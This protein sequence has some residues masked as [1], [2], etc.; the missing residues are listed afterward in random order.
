MSALP[1]KPVDQLVVQVVDKR[2]QPDRDWVALGAGLTGPLVALL[3]IYAVHRLTRSREREKSV[4]DLHKAIGEA[5]AGL[6]PVILMAWQDKD[7]VKRAAAIEQ[8]KWRLQQV[9]G[10][11]ERMRKMS[12]GFSVS[13]R[14]SNRNWPGILEIAL[15][16]EMGMLRDRLTADPFEDPARPITK[17]KDEE[18]EQAIGS[19]MLALDAGLLAWMK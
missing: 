18:I 9:G 4:Y 14:I 16:A 15:T 17:G 8:T 13:R 19:F 11:T 1:A 2:P 10:M 7:A 6:V 5:L 12:R 3:A